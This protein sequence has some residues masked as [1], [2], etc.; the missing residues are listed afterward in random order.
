MIKLLSVSTVD[1]DQNLVE[2][3]KDYGFK[4]IDSQRSVAVILPE[5]PIRPGYLLRANNKPWTYFNTIVKLRR[6]YMDVYRGYASTLCDFSEDAKQVSTAINL[7]NA[8]TYHM[9]HKIVTLLAN[10]SKKG[11]ANALTPELKQYVSILSYSPDPSEPCLKITC[12]CCD[13]YGVRLIKC[14]DNLVNSRL[15]VYAKF[16]TVP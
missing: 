13:T 2:L 14:I 6:H 8:L 5:C 9:S 11:A 7:L 1:S 10:P 16:N 3:L 4:T 12:V 15:D